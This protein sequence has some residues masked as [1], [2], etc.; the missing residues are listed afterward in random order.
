MDKKINK[1][2]FQDNLTSLNGIMKVKLPLG[3]FLI[4]PFFILLLI[5]MFFLFIYEVSNNN[6]YN[7][8]MYGIGI[9]SLIY[10]LGISPYFQKSNNFVIVFE[11]DDSLEGFKLY[12][13]GNLVKILY[14]LDY[15]GLFAFYNNSRKIKCISYENSKHISNFT[16]YIIINYLTEWLKQ[17]K[18]LSADVSNS[19]EAEI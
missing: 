3:I 19:Y 12:Y 15:D 17:K 16:K 14:Y 4:L 13:K 7:S 6:I 8:F 5:M 2:I 10:I 18:L 11:N 9:F 1:L